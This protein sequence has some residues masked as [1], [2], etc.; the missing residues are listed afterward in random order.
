MRAGRINQ[1]RNG[2]TEKAES[3]QGGHL[4]RKNSTHKGH[5]MKTTTGHVHRTTTKLLERGKDNGPWASSPPD[6]IL[7]AK[8][9]L[10]GISTLL[11]VCDSAKLNLWVKLKHGKWHPGDAAPIIQSK[12]SF[13]IKH[14]A[15]CHLLLTSLLFWKVKNIC[16]EP[17]I[18]K[19]FHFRWWEKGR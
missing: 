9:C 8:S 19:R 7:Q 13:I 1:R 12:A 6:H 3:I 4:V 15:S 11:V 18:V 14:T 17:F 10:G 2:G 16:Y 5:R